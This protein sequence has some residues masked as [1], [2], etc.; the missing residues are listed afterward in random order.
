MCEL[1]IHLKRRKERSAI[2]KLI[3]FNKDWI[4]K[5]AINK[6]FDYDKRVI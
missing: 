3:N 6:E 1:L 5:L 4:K 2:K